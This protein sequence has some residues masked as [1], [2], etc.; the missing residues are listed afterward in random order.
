MTILL[1]FNDYGTLNIF[2]DNVID[3][4]KS[5]LSTTPREQFIEIHQQM[6]RLKFR[7]F[8]IFKFFKVV[9]RQY[10]RF[11][12]EPIETFNPSNFRH[13]DQLSVPI[14]DDLL[15]P[16]RNDHLIRLFECQELDL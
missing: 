1:G 16:L 12:M 5:F 15:I 2:D 9:Y 3:C 6:N 7:P 10:T 11:A 13:D 8:K 14:R 4:I